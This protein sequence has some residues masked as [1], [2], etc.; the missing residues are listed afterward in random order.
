MTRLAK[1]VDL[2]TQRVTHPTRLAN[3]VGLN[4]LSG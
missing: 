2:P 4:G 3:R 1:R